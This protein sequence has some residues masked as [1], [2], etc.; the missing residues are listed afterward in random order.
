MAISSSLLPELTLYILYNFESNF[1]VIS[2]LQ[3]TPY[4]TPSVMAPFCAIRDICVPY[5]AI[6][7]GLLSVLSVFSV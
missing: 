5:I 2:R 4:K 1:L 7:D 3:A 6:C